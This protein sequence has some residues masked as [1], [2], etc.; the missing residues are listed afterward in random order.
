V[1]RIKDVTAREVLDCRGIPT[2][3]VNIVMVSKDLRMGSAI[4]PGGTSQGDREALDLRDKD[5]KRYFGQGVQNAISLILSQVRPA[6]LSREF[7][8][9]ADVDQVLT[10]LD[11]TSNRSRL[12][13]NATLAVSMAFTRAHASLLGVPI[14]EMVGRD[15]GASA[16]V[17]PV[18]LMT[19]FSGGRKEYHSLDIEEVMIVPTG[20]SKF[21]DAL[22]GGV[23]VFQKVREILNKK[24]K[25]MAV[26]EKGGFVFQL[27]P[28]GPLD[29]IFHLLGEAI[30]ETE[31]V[32]GKHIHFALNIAARNLFQQDHYIFE[33]NKLTSEQMI[34]LYSDLLK[35]YP[36]VS[37]EDGLLDTDIDGWVSMTQ[38]L[39][40]SVQLVGGDLFRSSPAE[41][42]KGA[43]K[44]IANA[45]LIKPNQVGTVTDCYI[46]VALA[47]LANYNSVI[48][49]RRGETE[50]SFLADLAVGSDACQIKTG[51]PLRSDRVA[52]YNQLLRIEQS[53][54]GRGI[55][56]G[57]KIYDRFRSE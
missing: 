55:F 4:A 29:Q 11:G 9:Q 2:V 21:S 37:I 52:K 18:P 3:E 45:L 46:A 12:G 48:A 16:T 56:V 7:Q 14:Y 28:E 35:K 49:H 41:L 57:H 8:S 19:I 23:E 1:A 34:S 6:L 44:K 13:A 30:T 5:A 38:K 15:L 53:L 51:G 39:G 31:Y 32:V 10:D 24:K 50:D 42:K 47:N 20:F 26:S 43:Q 40:N 54:G 36:I 33:G 25:C 27:E 17:L 22:R